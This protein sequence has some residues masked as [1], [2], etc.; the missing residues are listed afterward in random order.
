MDLDNFIQGLQIFQ[1]YQSQYK[2]NM[3]MRSY[4]NDGFLYLGLVSNDL[5]LFE[6]QESLLN[7]GFLVDDW[8]DCYTYYIG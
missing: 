3:S 6:D 4:D 5:I 1:K 7:L 2:F 8:E